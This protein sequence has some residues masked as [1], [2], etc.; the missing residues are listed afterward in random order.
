MKFVIIFSLIFLPFFITAAEKVDI[1]TASLEQLD[2]LI[3]VGP[4]LA[5]R[6][7]DARPFSSIDD[8]L[9]V[10]G[11]GPV[12]LEKIKSQ[13]LA[14]VLDVILSEAKNPVEQ[15][16]PSPTAQDDILY[17][18]NIFF[19]EAMP[20][21]EGDDEIGEYIKIKNGNDFEID[22]TGWKITDLIGTPKTYTLAEKIAPLGILSLSRQKTK[23][24]LN[25]SGD[26][27][28]LSNPSG[29]VIDSVEFG[30][31]NTGELY[32][33]TGSEWK[34]DE[35]TITKKET[36]AKNREDLVQKSAASLTESKTIDLSSSQPNSPIIAIALFTASLSAGFFLY[37]KKKI[38]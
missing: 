32:I 2:T 34:W 4:V 30:P 8:L 10:K 38:I 1:N 37:L 23:I 17:P 27:L 7:I 26:D 25:N 24:T 12:V 13:G 3:G 29:E 18:K 28:K 36:P 14:E 15:Q 35:P 21:P 16:D 9:E 11:I 22:L 20:S 33:K 31:A 6:I 19:V 5:Q